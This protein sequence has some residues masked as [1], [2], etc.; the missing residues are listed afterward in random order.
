MGRK[1]RLQVY[2][3]KRKIKV[4]GDEAVPFLVRTSGRFMNLGGMISFVLSGMI[5][6]VKS[7]FHI[8]QKVGDKIIKR[9]YVELRIKEK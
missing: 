2:K 4:S 1:L 5:M 8:K 7:F 3:P 6:G 9:K